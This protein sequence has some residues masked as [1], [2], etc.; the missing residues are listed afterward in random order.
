MQVKCY[1]RL[2]DTQQVPGVSFDFVW[3]ALLLYFLSFINVL[4][5]DLLLPS[6]S[7]HDSCFVN[8]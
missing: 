7:G 6:T 4:V 1:K 5:V 3:V 2:S 8:C